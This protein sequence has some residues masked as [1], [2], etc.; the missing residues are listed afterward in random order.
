MIAEIVKNGSNLTYKNLAGASSDGLP[1]GTVIALYTNSVPSGYLPCNG[2]TFDT[3]QYPALYILLGRNT[4]PDLREC[5]LVGIGESTREVII[6]HDVYTLGQFKDDQ[7]QEHTHTMSKLTS[8]G[9]QYELTSGQDYGFDTVQTS[10]NSGRTG[11]TTHGKNVGVNYAIKATT[12]LIDVSDAEIFAQ[13]V[14]YLQANYI[15]KDVNADWANS[16]H[17]LIQYDAVNNKWVPVDRPTTDS[18]VLVS[19]FDKTFAYNWNNQWLNGDLTAGEAVTPT[20]TPY[21]IGKMCNKSGSY[22]TYTPH[23]VTGFVFGT[24]ILKEHGAELA[25]SSYASITSDSTKV[26]SGVRAQDYY[27]YNTCLYYTHGADV[28]NKIT[29]YR[30]DGYYL[31][32][33]YYVRVSESITQEEYEEAVLNG[34]LVQVTV[35]ELLPMTTYEYWT[36]K[37]VTALNPTGFSVSDSSEDVYSEAFYDVYYNLAVSDDLNYRWTSNSG[38]KSMSF[39]GTRAEYEVAKLI[40][41]GQE[42]FIPSHSLIVITDEDDKLIGEDYE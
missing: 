26:L 2:V 18:Q 1:I 12:G 30:Y 3:T 15:E 6:N 27:L 5:N 38:S 14:A 20:E 36:V 19:D 10:V 22:Y 24:A 11:A 34:T 31:G 39:I 41:E 8:L 23:E 21:S 9:E 7:M 28:Y 32:A 42:G 16:E 29:G 17:N 13:V 33:D 35:E 25:P 4:T 37:E 40:P